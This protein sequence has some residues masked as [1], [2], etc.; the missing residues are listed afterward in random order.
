MW[1][2]NS[3]TADEQ[4]AATRRKFKQTQREKER[5][6]RLKAEKTAKLR[7]VRLAK[8]AEEEAA[9]VEGA[10]RKTGRKNTTSSN[11]RKE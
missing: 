9:L 3:S 6:W 1:S 5:I 7:S 8:E 2:T 4:L 11:R 10:A